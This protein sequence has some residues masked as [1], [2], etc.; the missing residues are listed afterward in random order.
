MINGHLRNINRMNNVVI[1]SGSIV[2]RA[3]SSLCQCERPRQRAGRSL[4]AVTS[5]AQVLPRIRAETASWQPLQQAE[6]WLPEFR[7]WRGL[8]EGEGARD[9][10]FQDTAAAGAPPPT[11]ISCSNI[12]CDL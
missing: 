3:G 12:Q 9:A 7:V 8:L 5:P 6:T 11:A 1:A 2:R 10:I 4:T